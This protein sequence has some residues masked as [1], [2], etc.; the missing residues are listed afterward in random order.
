[1]RFQSLVG[2]DRSGSRLL[3]ALTFSVA[4]HS[5]LLWAAQAGMAERSGQLPLAVTLRP[6]AAPALPAPSL[7]GAPA[8]RTKTA[9]GSSLARSAAA[10]PDKVAEPAV[11]AAGVEHMP[12]PASRA[13]TA[14]AGQGTAGVSAGE[15]AGPDADGIRAYRIGLAREA[16]NHRR[17][18]PLALERGWGWVG[19]VMFP[20]VNERATPPSAMRRERRPMP[21]PKRICR[22]LR[23]YFSC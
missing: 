7:Q 4:I 17:Y 15:G 23:I 16:R 19:A 6:A 11:S 13:E 14:A 1:V 2:K 20:S 5:I 10:G 8:P 3:P 18:P 12:G 21:S 22:R 9:S